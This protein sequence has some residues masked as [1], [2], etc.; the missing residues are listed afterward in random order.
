MLHLTRAGCCANEG[1]RT[2]FQVVSIAPWDH[3]EDTNMPDD[4]K[5]REATRAD[6]E[7]AISE[8]REKIA[9]E[10]KEFENEPLTDDLKAR[11]KTKRQAIDTLLEGYKKK[12]GVGYQKLPEPPLPPPKPKT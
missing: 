2:V 11:F 5:P 6:W 4:D 7:D 10:L 3:I 1:K 8:L 12:W 9:K